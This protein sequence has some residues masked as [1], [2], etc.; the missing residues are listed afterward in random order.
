VLETSE[1]ALLGG[2]VVLRQPASGY[3]AAIDPVLLAA[4]VPARAGERVLDLGCGVGAVALCVLARVPGIQATGV[5][6][7]P[8]L[9]ALARENAAGRAFGV[10]EGDARDPR[11]LAGDLFDHVATNPP[12]HD[13]AAHR[14]SP[15]ATKA[16]ANAG[17]VAD[18]APWLATAAR[19]LRPGGT[20]TIIQKAERLPDVLAALPRSLGRVVVRPV[21]RRAGEAATR[22]LVQA[23]KGRRTPFALAAPLVLHGAGG[24]WTAEL[25][26]ILRD[27]EALAW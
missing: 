12:Y 1:D 11:L 17:P 21:A 16:R 22:V 3:R 6:I 2:R 8:G 13:A 26:A 15:D 19:R 5:E 4:A 24:G 27:A 25:E 14:P 23:V 7:D 10:V 18:L 9:A 20:L